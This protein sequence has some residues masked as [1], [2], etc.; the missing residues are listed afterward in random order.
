MLQ[1][2]FLS[3][4]YRPRNTSTRKL[5]RHHGFVREVQYKYGEYDYAAE[6][7]DLLG[8]ATKHFVHSVR[9]ITSTLLEP[10]GSP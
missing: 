5:C 3:N 8:L 2:C 9:P 10:V 7:G 6:H 1:S 4:S